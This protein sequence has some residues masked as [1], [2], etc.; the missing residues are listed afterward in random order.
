MSRT[1]QLVGLAELG[2][3]V[4]GV[5]TNVN[6][7]ERAASVVDLVGA[8]RVLSDCDGL[9]SVDGQIGPRDMIAALAQKR[10]QIH[11][12]CNV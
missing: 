11:M 10:R 7:Q 3:D 1:S 2:I 9:V 4:P 12:P 8:V 5:L 6:G